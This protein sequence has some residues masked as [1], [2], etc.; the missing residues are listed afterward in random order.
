MLIWNSNTTRS[1]QD[2][3]FIILTLIYVSM[4]V[5]NVYIIIYECIIMFCIIFQPMPII[6]KF[7]VHRFYWVNYSINDI[8]HNIGIQVH[9]SLNFMSEIYFDAVFIQNMLKY[10]L[11]GRVDF[12][13]EFK[14]RSKVG[15][16]NRKTYCFSGK[17]KKLL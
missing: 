14:K 10:K 6:C 15:K 7:Y 12:V 11:R 8:I 2:D 4:S 17:H 3:Y 16:K 13:A 5:I 9:C 1:F